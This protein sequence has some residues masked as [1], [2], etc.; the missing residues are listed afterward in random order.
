MLS[1]HFIDGKWKG[2]IT[3]CHSDRKCRDGPHTDVVGSKV[4]TQPSHC[5]A[6]WVPLAVNLVGDE[7][8]R[9]HLNQGSQRSLHEHRELYSVSCNKQ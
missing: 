1:S 5:A 4:L 3:Q 7:Q 9:K 2:Q 6:S 8:S